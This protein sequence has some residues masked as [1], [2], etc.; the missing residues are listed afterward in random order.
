VL[1]LSDKSLVKG[2]LSW[3]LQWFM[4]FGCDWSFIISDFGKRKTI[5]EKESTALLTE[6][7]SEAIRCVR[8]LISC[9]LNFQKILNK[10]M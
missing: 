2:M 1:K 7:Q 10:R 9:F 6:N 5:S 3:L 8:I 4:N